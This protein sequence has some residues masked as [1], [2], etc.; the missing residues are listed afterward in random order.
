ME[1]SYQIESL[2]DERLFYGCYAV[3]CKRT[4]TG[5]KGIL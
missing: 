2:L 5:S 4:N 3:C 1:I